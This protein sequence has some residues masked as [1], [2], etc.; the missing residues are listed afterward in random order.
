MTFVDFLN[1]LLLAMTTGC[2][3][4]S[5]PFEAVAIQISRKQLY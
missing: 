3:K 1:H 4:K 2:I 5:R